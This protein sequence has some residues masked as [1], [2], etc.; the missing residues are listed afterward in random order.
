MHVE[1][2]DRRVELTPSE[3]GYFSAEIPGVGAGARYRFVLDGD[4]V[5]P[6]P[7]SRSQPEGV[8]GPSEVVDT[9]FRFQHDA[10][11]PP[12]LAQ[13]IIYE[14][15][16]GTFTRAGTFEAAID[17]LDALVDLGI[18]AI[19]IMPVA[20]FPGAR[21]WGYDGVCPFAAHADYGGPAGLAA[22]VDAC[23]ARGLAVVLDV[24]YNHL[25]PEGNYLG[26]FAPYFTDRYR[27]PWGPALE[28]DGPDSDEVRRYFIENAVMWL[29]DFHIDALRL[30]AVHAIVDASPRPF[31]QELAERVAELPGPKALIAESDAND[32]R[33]V[34]PPE[35]HGI[36]MDAVWADDFHHALHVVLTGERDGYY[37]DY[38]ERTRLCSAIE[39]GFAYR[40]DY[41][42][43]R[44]RRHGAP[45]DD[46]SPS[47]FVVCAQNHDQIGNRVDGSR[48][49][50]HT[51]LAGERLAAGLLLTTPHIPLLF[52]G[53]EYGETR[54]FAYF[55]S[56]GDPE[57]VEAVRRGRKEEFAS[58]GWEREPPD[59]QS[60]QT[61]LD[62]KLDR[63]RVHRSPHRELLEL[64]RS[65]VALR[66]EYARHIIGVRPRCALHDDGHT[67]AIVLGD[68]GEL[69]VIA[70]LDRSAR[71]ATL[72][73]PDGRW[74][75]LLDAEDQR[76][77]G[78]GPV[79]D[80][81]PQPGSRTALPGF[82]FA[83]LR[84]DA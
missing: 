56:H 58:F 48:L 82:W 83:V 59:P 84:R 28:L 69:A 64:H 41:S 81:Q 68:A 20:Q 10:F 42:V 12:P 32:P 18:N 66:R 30:D 77:G 8:H 7:A 60:T 63:D 57:L 75:V 35:Q 49:G 40:G 31:L 54:P 22:F 23:H 36:G 11:V 70:N 13:W 19:E 5:R 21:N 52:M 46:V 15:H 80:A 43:F 44:R 51:T 1:L 50:A 47:A 29:D 16:V 25:G 6:D 26:D 53:Q 17:H 3:R 33:L 61:F 34:I 62:S 78:D 73:L 71:T 39:H 65:L 76:F 2:D 24:V 72:A 79:L 67:L 37:A 14:L 55:T 45:T 74:T 4:R 9:R 38:V 27:T